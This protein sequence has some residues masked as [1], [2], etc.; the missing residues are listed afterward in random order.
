MNL[1]QGS[2]KQRTIFCVDYA[3]IEKL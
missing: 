1:L 3:V 2:G